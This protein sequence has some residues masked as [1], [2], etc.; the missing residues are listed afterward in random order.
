MYGILA[1]MHGPRRRLDRI[2]SHCWLTITTPTP[3]V[4]A[5]VFILKTL[6]VDCFYRFTQVES[7]S[8]LAKVFRPRTTAPVFPIA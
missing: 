5:K 8:L 7:G 3:R 4:F 1:L 2:R 6:K